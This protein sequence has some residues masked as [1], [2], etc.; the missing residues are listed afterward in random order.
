MNA[1][2]TALPRIPI[3]AAVAGDM[4]F[5]D[6]PGDVAW[7]LRLAQRIRWTGDKNHVA[8]L[9]TQ[10]P[11]GSWLIGQA[12]GKG[13]TIDKPLVLDVMKDVV[14]RLPLECDR[15]RFLLFGRAQVG[16]R[17]GFL[18]VL[19]ILA[20]MV[21]PKFVNVML[22]NTWICSAVV[23]E[24]LRFAGWFHDWPDVYQVAP[25]PLFAALTG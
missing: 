2:S 21:S 1:A 18:T 23:A 7:L 4:V 6:S 17:Y 20:T 16:R 8:W 11:D 25:D 13:V 10:R 9:D 5:F 19:S 22:P 3:D 24:A 12:E 14:V 15:A